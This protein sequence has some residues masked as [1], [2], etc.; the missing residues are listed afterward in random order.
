MAPGACPLRAEMLQLVFREQFHRLIDASP[1]L[2]ARFRR[3]RKDPRSQEQAMR[4][5]VVVLTGVLCLATAAAAQTSNK[6]PSEI[7]NRANGFSYQ[8]TPS[9]VVPREKEA[10]IR[11]SDAQEKA[12]N[13][14]LDR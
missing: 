12:A 1:M 11:P 7:G 10:G 6:I 5:H 13:A 9:Q 4:L 14:D 3:D 2:L 8:P